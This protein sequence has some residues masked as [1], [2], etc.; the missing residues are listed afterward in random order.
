VLAQVADHLARA[1]GA[2]YVGAGAG[3]GT[4]RAPRGW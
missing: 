4:W 2:C 1:R 3:F